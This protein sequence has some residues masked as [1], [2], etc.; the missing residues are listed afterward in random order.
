M[1]TAL[2]AIQLLGRWT[3]LSGRHIPMG[4]GC[5]CGPG[6]A[7]LQLKDFEEQLLDY[8]RGRH[9]EIVGDSMVE[10]LQRISKM[11]A[12]RDK[13][14]LQDLARSLDSFD[15]LHRISPGAGCAP[16]G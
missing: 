1:S 10:L 12:A 8:L 14:L 7:S 15:E 3:Q 4:A 16:P 5:S 11:P 2:S 13:A 6:F 9:G